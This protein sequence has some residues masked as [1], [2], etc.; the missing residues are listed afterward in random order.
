M[1]FVL[2]VLPRLAF[3]ASEPVIKLKNITINSKT[4]MESFGLDK[5]GDKFEFGPFEG[6]DFY[7]LQFSGPVQEDWKNNLINQGVEIL[8]YIPDNTF[9]AKIPTEMG[10][11]AVNQSGHVFAVL[12]YQPEYKVS[13][14]F[15]TPSV[16]TQDKT[17]KTMVKL[18]STNV[19]S[20]FFTQAEKLG[21]KFVSAINKTSFILEIPINKIQSISQIEGVEWMEPFG[22]IKF[23]APQQEETF[24]Q[25]PR[26]G[27][28][29]DLTGYESG[30]K[31]MNL[32][33]AWSKG[34]HGEGQVV[35]L[36]DTGL[37]RGSTVNILDDFKGQ[38]LKGYTKALF[39]KN[40]EDPE[41][42][43]THTAG[44]IVGTGIT[45]GGKLRGAAYGAK[46]V[47]EALWSPILGN[48]GINTNFEDVFISVYEA[49]G[50][51]IHSD[52]WGS[53]KNPSAYDIMSTSLDEVIWSHPDLLVVFSA[54]NAGVDMNGDGHIDA[55]SLDT[56]ATAKN[57]LTVGA[58]KNLVL[59]G[60]Y[61]MKLNFK[62]K[63]AKRYPAE[64]I[65]SSKFS[66]NPDG[67]APFSSI[68]PTQ[69]G[70]IK[71]DIVAP[72]T[73]IISTRSQTPDSDT[74]WGVYNKF[75][76]YSGGTSMST[77]LVAGA[78][79]VTRQYLKKVNGKEP[80]AALVKAALIHNAHD[81]F[82]GQFGT[83]KNQEYPQTRPNMNE[84]FGRVDMAS[85]IQS[86]YYFADD[87]EGVNTGNAK[88]Y[89]L[90]LEK[91]V[92]GQKIRATMVY[93][94]APGSPGAATALVND[95][96]L[97]VIDAA[98]GKHFP[99]HLTVPD[100]KNNVEMVEF[101]APTAGAYRVVVSGTSVPQGFA[102]G[103]QPFALL[104]NIK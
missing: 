46:L 61:Q 70:R 56:P 16:F 50:V 4:A 89:T 77:P 71:P 69:D 15:E 20:T 14:T 18:V 91:V 30:T 29:T 54:G 90:G 60:G 57:C 24:S 25:P 41:G 44:S 43:G 96:D 45:S 103:K 86:A 9:I 11:R 68:G 74:L 36:A 65:S 1:L 22:E 49:D 7:L 27:D 98:G 28:Y 95:L 82:P 83:G 87:R 19:N 32:D 92:V 13:D 31:L 51:R 104:W 35:G 76:V 78:A 55:S 75:Y 26:T 3:G 84:G 72:G 52:S 94:D 101:T 10:W 37:D 66:E 39:G 59:E 63:A 58:S 38:I 53:Q 97:V 100:R 102:G 80:S 12:P 88:A 73:N 67:M 6:R 2:A 48:L 81:L 93:T 21:A 42:H 17:E 64:P 79:A 33:A 85:V 5:T 62:P 8:S 40:W 23:Q 34:F 47:E 99:N